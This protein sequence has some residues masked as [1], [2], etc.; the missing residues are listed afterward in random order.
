MNGEQTLTIYFRMLLT[1]YRSFQS[2]KNNSALLLK[3][4]ILVFLKEHASSPEL[5][6]LV[7]LQLIPDDWMLNDFEGVGGIYQFLESSITH[8]LHEKRTTYTAKH[9][10]EMDLLNAEYNLV[11]AKQAYLRFTVKKKC[12]ICNSHI[13]DKV[14]YLLHRYLQCTPMLM[15]AIKGVSKKIK[16][17]YAQ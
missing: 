5:D 4:D 11:Q 1:M 6:P 10:S 9:L 15:Y 17:L 12:C 16:I 7:V 8:T 14:S 2:S 13:A 3:K